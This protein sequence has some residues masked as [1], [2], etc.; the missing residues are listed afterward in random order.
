MT[1]NEWITINVIDPVGT[2]KETT[3]AMQEA[4]PELTRVRGHYYCPA[5]GEREHWWLV[6]PE[7]DIVDPTKAQFP[8]HHGVYVPW[9]EDAEEP[10]GI[11]LNCGEYVYDDGSFCKDSCRRAFMADLIG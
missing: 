5:W 3:L 8:S 9:D 2:C 7:G 4:F 11:C 10:S 6:D 1:Y